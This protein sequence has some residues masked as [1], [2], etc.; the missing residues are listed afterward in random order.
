MIPVGERELPAVGRPRGRMAGE[1][2]ALAGELPR[3]LRRVA[4]VGCRR[5]D[6]HHAVAIDVVAQALAVGA[7]AREAGDGARPRDLCPRARGDVDDPDLAAH[8]GPRIHRD[9][10]SVGAPRGVAVVGV[11]VG[12]LA[13]VPAIG[14]HDVDVVRAV[15]IGLERDPLAVGAPDRPEVRGAR[16]RQLP[17][18]RRAERRAAADQGD[19]GRETQDADERR[20]GQASSSPRAGRVTT[21]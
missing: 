5:P 15:P 4:A 6:V 7:P 13:D 2:I 10:L 19:A 20:H 12:E 1:V 8:V 3:E 16:L 14:V 17:D 11:A 18:R 21:R 9:E